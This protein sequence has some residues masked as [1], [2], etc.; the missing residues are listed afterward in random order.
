MAPT[1]VKIEFALSPPYQ[2]EIIGSVVSELDCPISKRGTF[3]G[4]C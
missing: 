3:D 2:G 1:Q 4:V